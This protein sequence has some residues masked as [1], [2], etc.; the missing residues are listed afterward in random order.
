M[1]L[2][3]PGEMHME[4]HDNRNAR[5]RIAEWEVDPSTNRVIRGAQETK[6]EPKVM[7]VL[8]FLAARPG[9]TVSRAELEDAVWT[10]TVV[11]YDAITG[12]IQKL[13]RVFEDEPS[14]PRYIETLSKKGYRLI[15]AV[16]P[17]PGPTPRDA[18]PGRPSAAAGQRWLGPLPA[19]AVVLAVLLLAAVG[20]SVVWMQHETPPHNA[21]D[22]VAPKTVAVLPFRNLGDDPAQDYF[23]E[24][25]SDDLIASLARFSDLHVIARDSTALYKDTTM[26][27][28][29]LADRLNIRYL[30]QGNVRREDQRLRINVQLVNSGSGEIL[31]SERFD[32]Q[33]T[34]L[35]Q[36]QDRI[37]HKTVVAL[38]GQMNIRDRQELSRPKTRSLQAYDHFLYGRQQFFLYADAE[39]NRNAR[40]SFARAI[41]IDQDFAMAYAMLAWT[42]AFD[43]MNG[44]SGSR[45]DSLERAK[46]LALK[47][48][49]LDEAMPVAHFVRGVAYRELGEHDH[50]LIEARKAIALDPNYAGALV[51]QATLLY[52]NGKP[53]EGLDLMKKAIALH[54]HH[55]YNYSFHLGQAFYIL[56]RYEEAIRAF[57]KVLDSNP[58]SERAHLWLAAAY[59]QVGRKDDAEWETE[60][61]LMANPDLSMARIQSAYPFTDP[62]DREH[63]VAGL[64]NAGF[65]P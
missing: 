47:A 62:A 22:A 9:Q 44:W 27:P 5:F 52:F 56:Q 43:A 4:G 51:L 50:A 31:W 26:A 35:F 24:G 65:P 20:T 40:E 60:Q 17:L 45:T 13:R 48:V 61:V 3:I 8:T 46:S 63:F 57:E 14:H 29:Q 28:A 12:A 42:H 11:G 23:A 38:T 7:A 19:V 6:L 15:A 34:N 30:V 54:P 1:E 41:A 49:E 55:P 36:L 2:G 58:A 32:D 33:A 18:A 64:N 53:S 10:G 16:T 59:A 25:L 37:T 21:V 39:H